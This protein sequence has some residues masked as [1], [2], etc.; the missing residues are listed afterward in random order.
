MDD[1]NEAP[2]RSFKNEDSIGGETR[3]PDGKPSYKSWKTRYRKMRISFDQKMTAGQDLHK[4]EEKAH[5]TCNRLAV[6]VE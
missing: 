4:Q 3:L 5:Q 6:D 2:A 1:E